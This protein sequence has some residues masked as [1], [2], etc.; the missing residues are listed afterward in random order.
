MSICDQECNKVFSKP[1]KILYVHV[2]QGFIQLGGGGGEVGY[3]PHMQQY[4]SYKPS[5]DP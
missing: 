5:G 2:H 4:L 3:P 1:Q